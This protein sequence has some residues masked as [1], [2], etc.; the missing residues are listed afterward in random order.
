MGK[1]VLE[2]GCSQ[3][4]YADHSIRECVT[5]CNASVLIYKD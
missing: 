5:E 4:L 2:N 3:G 1:C